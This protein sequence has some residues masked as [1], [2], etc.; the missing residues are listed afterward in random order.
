MYKL[1]QAKLKTKNFRLPRI[2]FRLIEMD[3][4][5]ERNGN[6]NWSSGETHAD[7][8]NQSLWTAKGGRLINA[9]GFSLSPRKGIDQIMVLKNAWRRAPSAGMRF[10]GGGL[11]SECAT[12][13]RSACVQWERGSD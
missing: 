12:E 1:D 4:Q 10:W 5:E 13:N 7:E 6:R 8:K 2:D 3:Q 9:G 11:T